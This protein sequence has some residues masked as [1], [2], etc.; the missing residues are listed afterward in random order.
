M[1]IIVAL[2][3]ILG[4]GIGLFTFFLVKSI[5]APKQVATLQNGLKQGKLNTVVR[6][7]KQIIAKNPQSAEAHYFLGLAYT[8]LNKPELGLMELKTVN[9]IGVFEGSVKEAEFRKKIAELFERFGQI[10]EALK[11]YLLLIRLE[12]QGADHYFKAGLLFEARERTDKAINYYRKTIELDPRHSDAHYCLGY[13]LFRGKKVLEAKKEFEEA[14]RFNPNNYKAHFYFGKLQKDSHDYV[15]AL[16]SF[17]K[18]QR[19]QEVKIK[20]LVERG[21]CYMHMNSFDKAVV[22]LERAIKLSQNDSAQ[23]T[24]FAR[25]FLA[26]CHEKG[27]NFDKA[28]EQW[29][30]IYKKKPSFRDVAEKLSQ[31]QELRTDDKI[32]DYL[33][34]GPTEF[35]EICKA[36][37]TSMNLN[38][39]DTTDIKNGCQIIAVESDSKWRNAKK[40]PKLLWFLRV[41]ETITDSTVRAIL[42]EMKKLS[43]QRGVI[44]SSS[45]F[46]RKALDFSESRPVELFG[47]D[48]FQAILKNVQLD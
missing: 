23:E 40:M 20:A 2:I 34:A 38:I 30:A 10:E 29:E 32:K 11:E 16:L 18:A 9:Q 22:E 14:L 17:E 39:R 26:L 19:D 12:P 33:T 42:D 15:A 24:L 43:V 5:I 27:R 3:I 1:P 45:G 28:I 37:A 6:Q 41:P 46:S 13:A 25:Y 8:G 21:S 47:K 44:Y 4:M 35:I 31:Y 48:E 7:A 36:V